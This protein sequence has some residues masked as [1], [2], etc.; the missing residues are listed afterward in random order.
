MGLIHAD[1]PSCDR[2]CQCEA[3]DRYAYGDS[4]LV[5]QCSHVLDP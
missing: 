4:P 3:Y 5:H 2:E 1:P